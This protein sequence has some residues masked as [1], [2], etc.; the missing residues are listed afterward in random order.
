MSN[1]PALDPNPVTCAAVSSKFVVLGMTDG[2]LSLYDVFGN[3]LDQHVRLHAA[4]VTCVTLGGGP[5]ADSIVASAAANGDIRVARLSS[6]S[7][8]DENRPAAAMLSAATVAFTKTVGNPV[9]ALAVD[10]SFGK[11]RF[12]QRVAFSD[13]AGRVVIHTA[14]WFWTDLVVHPSPA[15]SPALA[16]S[17]QPPTSSSITNKSPLQQ[18]E[19]Q[20][21]NPILSLAWVHYLLAYPTK[22]GV[23]VYD[24]KK[25]SLVCRVAAPGVS[26]P[27]SPGMDRT[28]PVPLEQSIPPTNP[29]LSEDN[30]DAHPLSITEASKRA[31]KWAPHL[32]GTGTGTGGGVFVSPTS[33]TGK[34]TKAGSP[35][36][37]QQE[38]S[39]WASHIRVYMEIDESVPLSP[40]GEPTIRL[41]LTWPEG[42]RIVRVGPQATTV[43]GQSVPPPGREIDVIFKLERHALVLP[44][45]ASLSYMPSEHDAGV[46]VPSP[47]LSVEESPLLS[48]VPFGD[49]ECVALVGLPSRSICLHLVSPEGRSLKHMILPPDSWSF[50]DANMLTVPG[51]D[52]L[53]LVVAYPLVSDDDTAGDGNKP[54]SHP[55]GEQN[56]QV[57]VEEYKN[58]V[59]Q[60]SNRNWTDKS[61]PMQSDSKYDSVAAPAEVMYV[62]SLTTA[63]RVKWLLAED[64]FLD[65]LSVAQSAPGGS[66]RRAEVSLVDIGEQFLE[67][68]KDAGDFDRLAT[69]LP[70][71]ISTT[72][73]FAGFRSRDRILKKRRLRWERWIDVFR[74]A[75]QLAMVASVIPT[76]EPLLEQSTYTGILCD[77]SASNPEVMVSILKTWPADVFDVSTVTKSIEEE[78]DADALSTNPA[79][80][81]KKGKNGSESDDNR[82]NK[83]TA[84]KWSGRDRE[85]LNE[86]LLMLY[87]LSGRHDE[88]LLFL[89]RDKSPKV[90]D[91]IRSHHLYEAVR[92]AE[93]ITGLYEINAAAATDVLSHAP[94]TVLPPD[95]VVPLLNKVG[96]S[97]WTFMYLHAVFRMDVDQAPK[98][99]NTLLRLYVKH[100][101]PGSL[102]NFLR[103]ST[104]YSLDVALEVMGGPKG[105]PH[106]ALARERVYTLSAMGDLN[107]AMDILL[108]ELGDT[109]AAIEFATDHGDHVLW[110]RLIEHARTHADTLA[111]LLDSP[112]GGKVDPVRL[113]PL[114]RSEMRIPNLRDRLH[115]ILVDA[116]LERALREDAASALQYDAG[117]LLNKLDE[118]VTGL[119]L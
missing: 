8:Q 19:Q 11:P 73:P 44:T 68:L 36:R 56:T 90:Y 74:S 71:T 28:V 117:Q 27:T 20:N 48:V 100:G 31:G 104:H 54:R 77:L 81:G 37:Q 89:L 21:E 103:T 66:L 106:G 85:A 4:P 79:A 95:A 53:V 3:L 92:S 63:E 115:R 34:K 97:S 41:Y 26:Q 42:A 2:S 99:H 113:V 18:Q 22:D 24:T 101:P 33:G 78:L 40:Q 72:S 30:I 58:K 10:P 29:L 69:V 62:R 49:G 75:N 98:Y 107:S 60:Q 91:Y 6:S 112:A 109:F 1:D 16:A 94:E 105:K 67:S 64:R 57:H 82:G 80:V 5:A 9:L 118:S 17:S 25:S 23:H 76:Y 65:A 51:G 50:R 111:A 14:G 70:E 38:L 7:S 110:E 13:G 88:T 116:A 83:G 114:L 52:P 61:K 55:P 102:Y 96:N 46:A 35:R 119:H 84:S 43:S 86:G 39:K 15:A 12:G 59:M 93:T 32:S 45:P 47:P 108:D 87:A